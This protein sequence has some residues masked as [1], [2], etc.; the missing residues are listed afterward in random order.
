MRTLTSILTL[1][2]L[3]GCSAH[4]P[5]E[6]VGPSVTSPAPVPDIPIA[7]EVADHFDLMDRSGSDAAL[8]ASLTT[9]R[10]RAGIVD[11]VEG[12]YEALTQSD[13]ASQEDLPGLGYARWKAVSLLGSLGDSAAIEPLSRIAR[14]ALPSPERVSEERFATEYRI[15][16]RAI[17]GLEA[18]KAVDRLEGFL[19]DSG[20][21]RGAV[22][23]SLYEL[24]RPPQGVVE[25]DKNDEL[26]IKPP[27][28]PEKGLEEGET[29]IPAAYDRPQGATED[30]KIVP[31]SKE[32]N[33]R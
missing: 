3:I 33:P 4:R 9:L 19:G 21:L 25:I 22:A 6:E 23:A 27:K 14:M 10:A 29:E 17:A 16:L 18:L 30:A 2:L 13:L 26:T 8:D 7:T 1:C 24:G 32:R 31:Q 15:R 28:R 11:E 20:L 12:L 5:P